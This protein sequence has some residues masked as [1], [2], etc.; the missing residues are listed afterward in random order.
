MNR[1]PGPASQAPARPPQG[2]RALFSF[3]DAPN[4]WPIGLR[5]SI[6]AGTPLLAGW[7][8]GQTAAGLMT[9]LGALT[10]LYG[11]G[12]PYLNRARYLAL[13]ALSF[14]CT[15]ALGMSVETIPML[16]VATVVVIAMV[17]TYVCSALRVGGAGAYM[18]T[19]I[20]A[21]GTALPAA[22]LA[23]WRAGLLVLAGGAFA[24]VVHMVPALFRT[25]GPEKL[26][27][28]AAG[29]AVAAYARAGNA[30]GQ[31]GGQHPAALALNAA[32][33][34]L[35]TYQPTHVRQGD[36]L[37]RQG[38]TLK[39]LQGINR[40]L[41]LLFAETVRTA[42]R[43]ETAHPA[44]AEKSRPPGC[45]RQS[46]TVGLARR[47]DPAGLTRPLGGPAGR[48]RRR[49]VSHLVVLRVGVAALLYMDEYAAFVAR[50]LDATS[51]WQIGDEH[52]DSHK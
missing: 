47:I 52:P 38:D 7:L 48:L 3:R 42:G 5:A 4:R 34:A 26:T 33:A 23:P 11:S 25:R 13:I 39:R 14:A 16:A 24:W 35:V 20:C 43:G 44:V 49:S 51:P 30:A 17:S 27:V 31:P 19:P 45:R 1:H 15:V 8:A 12:R 9:S 22:G 6:S 50:V 32:W 10:A 21:A 29:R 46:P 18:F 28:A 41:H 40:Q 36:T 2:I 37:K